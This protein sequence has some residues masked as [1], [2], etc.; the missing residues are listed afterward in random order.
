MTERAKRPKGGVTPAGARALAGRGMSRRDFLK[1]AGTGLAGASLLG[2][3]GCG[4]GGGGGGGLVSITLATTP[5][6]SGTFQTLID[7]FNLQ[8]EGEI[9]V[10]YRVMPPDSSQV[11]DQ[12]RTEFQAGSPDISVFEGD[13]TWP[14]Q[15]AVPGFIIDLSDRFTEHER[16]G[17]LEGP[18]QSNVYEGGIYGVP[19]RTDAGMLYYRQDL[20]EESGFTEPQTT[21]DE[22]KEMARTVQQRS[23]TRYGF[24]FQ[25][26]DYEG[27]VVNGLEYINS[28][29]GNVLD[30]NDSS[31]V[32]IDSPEAR[33]GLSIERSM[34]EDDVTPQAVSTYKED[35]STAT[36]L[37]GDAVFLRNWP[38]VY[39]QAGDPATSTISQDQIGIAP[40]PAASGGRSVSGLGGWNLMINA[41]SD[42]EVQDAAYEFIRFATAAEQQR[43]LAV[44]GSYLPVLQELYEDQEV[45][46]AVPVIA[47]GREAIQNTV[48]RPVSPYYSDMSL[49][50]AEQFNASLNG[51]VAPEE[52]VAT[53]QEELTDIIEQGQA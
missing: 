42:P 2:V 44:E 45:L 13:V 36:F 35:E 12:L 1:I 26:A 14:A 19:W 27:G 29:G 11:F 4:G 49:A 23:G 37:N 6:P 31:T 48:P 46:D 17:F 53:L 39:A 28:A 16:H 21:W 30:P 41:A 34:V 51:E 52:A 50:M 25:G 10:S 9:E 18:V 32:T 33:E 24:V 8:N 22:L 20:L 7:Q 3:A 43:T 38:Y 5:D 40:L 47:L 15:F